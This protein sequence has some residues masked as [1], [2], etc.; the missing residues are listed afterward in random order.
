MKT[1]DGAITLLQEIRQGSQARHDTMMT[2]GYDVVAM[3]GDLLTRDELDAISKTQPII[4]WDASEHYVFANSA[5]ITKYGI[6]NE[7]VAKTIGAGKNPDGSSN[8]QFLGTEAAKI[9]ILKPLS[10][11][12]TPEEGRK[13]LRYLGA[14]MQQAGIT[15]TGDLFY[16]G[17]NLDLENMLTA[18][19][20]RPA[21]LASRAS[22]MSPTASPSR[23]SMATAPSTR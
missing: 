7:L 1:R 10:E 9:I 15:T 11:I 17:V 21:E 14:L 5:A 2:W 3:G 18:R 19:V 12:L 20:F 22:C 13:R 4:V 23:N 16:G 6:T 8:G